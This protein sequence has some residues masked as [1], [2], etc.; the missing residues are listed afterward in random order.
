MT[1]QGIWSKHF[2]G[3]NFGIFDLK[4]GHF[5]HT[6]THNMQILVMGGPQM[7][8]GGTLGQSDILLPTTLQD[9]MYKQS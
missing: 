3:A 6:Q 4:I 5:R 2:G 7:T 9:T 8:C 1:F